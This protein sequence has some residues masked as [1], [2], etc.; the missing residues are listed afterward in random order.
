MEYGSTSPWTAVVTGASSGIGAAFARLLARQ[1]WHVVAVG[2]DRR[3]L[4][5]LAA[6]IGAEV[7]VADLLDT[8]DLALVENRVREG[9]QLL[10]NN[11]G[12]TTYG[13]FAELE[14]PAEL[15]QLTLH[16]A[17]PLRLC[18]AAAQTMA[19]GGRIINIASLAGLGAAPGL[20]SYGASKAALISLSES[21]HHELRGKAITVTCVCAGY[22]RTELQARAGVDAS[23]LPSA[24]WAD[25]EFVARRA[26]AA[27]ERGRALTIPGRLNTITAALLRHLPRSLSRHAAA[28]TYA[29]VE[30][31][32]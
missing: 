14:L 2:R 32:N 4:D 24:M 6:E 17:V 8:H 23:A 13:N 19:P 12:Y 28:R 30:S 15:G 20:A 10:I 25:P 31:L 29:R 21:L 18:H 3:R 16:A 5:E 9:V 27:S 26:L 7:L 22:T 1:G 11:A